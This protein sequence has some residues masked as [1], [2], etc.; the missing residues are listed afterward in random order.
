MLSADVASR[1]DALGTG[2]IAIDGPSGSGKSTVARRVA[3]RLGLDYLDTGATYR[4]VT[5]AVLTAHVDPTDTAAVGAIAAD[6]LDRARLSLSLA[7]DERWVLLDGHEVSSAIR[8][9]EVTAAVSAVSAVPAVRE[10]LVSWQRQLVA[11]VLGCVVEG[12]DVGA[13]VLP[14]A[15]VKIW[16]TATAEAR[17]RRRSVEL[18]TSPSEVL[19]ALV[20]RD[21]LDADRVIAPA[22]PAA[23]AVSMDTTSMTIDDVVSAVVAR[24]AAVGIAPRERKTPRD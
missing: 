16:L 23:D 7:P 11:S 10:Q 12:R 14:A 24:A 1:S 21:G 9:P 4:T 20:R 22:R 8:S 13:V 15:P 2:C 18:S 17:A 19:A 5:L 3:S 6:V